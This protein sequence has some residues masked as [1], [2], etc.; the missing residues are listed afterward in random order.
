VSMITNIDKLQ[1]DQYSN[2]RRRNSNGWLKATIQWSLGAVTVALATLANKKKRLKI[3]TVQKRWE[4]QLEIRNS[5]VAVKM[6]AWNQ[7]GVAKG[8]NKTE[9]AGDTAVQP[10]PEDLKSNC[11]V[12]HSSA[13]LPPRP[14]C[15]PASEQSPLQLPPQCL[16]A[17]ECQRYRRLFKLYEERLVV[18]QNS[19]TVLMIGKHVET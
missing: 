8:V 7:S 17:R 13:Q 16:L 6:Q 9:S 18:K 1:I 10:S 5:G 14:D 15:K 2:S 19:Q 3:S 12:Q 4:A 11:K